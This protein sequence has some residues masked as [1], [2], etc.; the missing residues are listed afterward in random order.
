[1][2][3][4][5]L[6]IFAGSDA[7]DADQG[8][9][10]TRR[11]TEGQQKAKD[12]E[13]TKGH[14][15]PDRDWKIGAP[16]RHGLSAEGLE[17]LASVAGNYK[18][19]CMVVIHDGVLVGEWY[20][21]GFTRDTDV[22][23]VFSVTKSIT[24]TLV[25]IAEAEGHLDIRKDAAS[26]IPNWSNA[27]T[28]PVSVRNLISN[29]SGRFWSFES[30]YV[31]GL[32]PAVDQS[33]YAVGLTQQFEPG[34][35][36]EYNNAAVQTLEEVLAQATRRDVG[37]YAQEKLFEPIG[38]T[39]TMGTDPSG[40]PLTY[41]GVS[42]SCDDM[43]RF[44]YLALRQGQWKDEQVVPKQWLAAATEPSTTLNDAYGYMWWLNRRGH[45]VTPSFP[46]RAEYD[47][48]LVP[49][50][51]EDVYVALGAFGQLVIV[52]PKQEYVIVRLQNV[53]DL[54]AELAVSPDPIGVTQLRAIL[55]AFE[56]AKLPMR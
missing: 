22:A 55:T 43:A 2:V 50:A 41:Q 26:Y 47:G 27:T 19:S 9:P 4:A 16:E 53:P 56:D 24:S 21:D 23:N 46:A 17:T 35:V 54:Q 3:L 29:D 12:H 37:S 18:T 25:G 15:Y 10:E 45:V 30:D 38:A 5:L 1:M 51:S 13:N 44:G 49:G 39:A 6:L 8:S 42:A 11:A 28:K 36:W 40:N 33:A 31:T 20:W 52:D 7:V 34:T 14:I 32:L 48:Q